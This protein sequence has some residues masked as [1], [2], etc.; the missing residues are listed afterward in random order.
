MRITFLCLFIGF[1][2]LGCKNETNKATIPSSSNQIS[3]AQDIANAYGFQH[4][5]NIKSLNFTFNI[6]RGDN[7]YERTFTWNPKTDDILFKSSTDTLAYNRKEPLDSLHLAADQR[8]INDKYWLLAPFQLVWDQNLT[9][10]EQKAVEAPISKRSM[11]VLTAV[12]PNEG[13]YTPGDA[14]DFYYTD[15]YM[16]HEWVFRE[17]NQ[18]DP[19]IITTWENIMDLEGMRFTLS[20]KD[21]TGGFHLYFTNLSIK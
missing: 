2:L 5:K 11:N 18:S 19:S 8:F 10:S 9:F 16:I 4:W 1:S 3:T 21:S 20:H 12:Y 15:D 13:G 7:H 6:D 14:Y 17:S